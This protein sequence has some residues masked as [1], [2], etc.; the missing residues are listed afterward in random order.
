MAN[1]GTLLADLKH[2]PR[3]LTNDED[4]YLSDLAQEL[5]RAP[6]DTARWRIL[7]REGIH[8][9]DWSDAEHDVLDKMTAL[10]RAALN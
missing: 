3:Q 6:N 7:E 9:V 1:L 10:H 8:K 4:T 2:Q 5:R